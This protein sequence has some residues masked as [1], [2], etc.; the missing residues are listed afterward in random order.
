M[1]GKVGSACKYAAV[2][3]AAAVLAVVMLISLYYLP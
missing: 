3:I 2:V 1:R